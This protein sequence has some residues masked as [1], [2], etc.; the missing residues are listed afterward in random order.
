MRV[1]ID[2]DLLAATLKASAFTLICPDACYIGVHAWTESMC[3]NCVL[4]A[5]C[6]MCVKF[7]YISHLVWPELGKI[8]IHV[9]NWRVLGVVK[10]L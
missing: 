9:L 1:F 7:C 3:Q 6:Y 10:K 4:G 8:L 5:V 2:K